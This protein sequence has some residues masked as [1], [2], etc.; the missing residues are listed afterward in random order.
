MTFQNIY[1]TKSP[2]WMSHFSKYILYEMSISDVFQ[3]IKH[4]G[5]GLALKWF[6]PEGALKCWFMC[7]EETKLFQQVLHCNVPVSKYTLFRWVF[8]LKWHFS[9]M[10]SCVFVELS[11]KIKTLHNYYIVMIFFQ[12]VLQR[13]NH[14][15]KN[16]QLYNFY[17]NGHFVKYR[18]WISSSRFSKSILLHKWPFRKV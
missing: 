17:I 13:N 10:N 6:F 5:T 14:G 1:F 3:V 8:K 12:C 7:M 9:C 18:F 4:F 2:I 11:R 15:P 16:I